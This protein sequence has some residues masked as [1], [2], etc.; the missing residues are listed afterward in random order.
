MSI[1]YSECVFVALGTQ[2]AIRTLYIFICGPSGSIIFFHGIS[3][4]ARFSK[5][6]IE[7]KMCALI[8]LCNFRLPHSSF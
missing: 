1:T 2:H 3:Q 7:H 5:N 4:T 6:V 8:V